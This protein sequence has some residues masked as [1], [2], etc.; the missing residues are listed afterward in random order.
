MMSSTD[1]NNA[2]LATAAATGTPTTT[3]KTM[4]TAMA[5]VMA[6]AMAMAM[7]KVMV[8]GLAMAMAT[9]TATGSVLESIQKSR[10]PKMYQYIFPSYRDDSHKFQQNQLW[11]TF[12]GFGLFSLPTEQLIS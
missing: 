3:A 5:T 8:T 7:P 11:M 4:A 1:N 12:G 2:V 10:P 6:M 9:A